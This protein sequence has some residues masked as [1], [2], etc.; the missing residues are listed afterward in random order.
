MYNTVYNPQL[1]QLIPNLPRAR[2]V[3]L[4][5]VIPP[6]RAPELIAMYNLRGLQ[7]SRAS[8]NRPN[9][10]YQV[11][12]PQNG[13]DYLRNF[14]ASYRSTCT[15]K[16]I[17]Y[18][19]STED[20]RQVATEL[21]CVAWHPNSDDYTRAIIT[22]H[23]LTDNSEGIKVVVA[24]SVFAGDIDIRNVRLVVHYRQPVSLTELAVQAGRA[25][26]D[27]NPAISLTI[28]DHAQ[29]LMWA[30]NP[31]TGRTDT[32]EHSLKMEYFGPTAHCRRFVLSA[33]V[34]GHE[35]AVVCDS[36]MR[37]E[38]CDLCYSRESSEQSTHGM[39]NDDGYQG[40]FVT[41][42]EVYS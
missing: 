9:I 36:T 8:T 25:G 5:S 29:P 40:N 14:L 6:N 17:I 4:S 37:E 39:D 22:R 31:A 20:V 33:F 19:Q 7:E 2:H 15:G 21:G 35:H 10:S 11:V 30:V 28:L 13:L 27:G 3:L 26:R 34:D 1:H 38:L 18:C 41:S 24:T 32:Y 12:K 23:F 42:V 16:I